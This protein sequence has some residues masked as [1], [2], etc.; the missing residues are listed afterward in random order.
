MTEQEQIKIFNANLKRLMTGYSQKEVAAAIG[1]NPQTF[2]TWMTG[3]HIPRMDK[4]QKL[5]DF[6]GVKSRS[7]WMFPV[8]PR[9]RPLSLCSSVGRTSAI[10]LLLR[11]TYLR[12][13]SGFLSSL[14]MSF[15]K[16]IEVV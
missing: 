5:A 15:K 12:I 8:K 7:L 14:R 4:I 10:L 2:N 11:R 6:F 16:N 13:K 3:K 9:R 1:V